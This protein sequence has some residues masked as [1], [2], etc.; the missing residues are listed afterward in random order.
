M[1]ASPGVVQ[2]KCFVLCGGENL[3]STVIE[4]QARYLSRA[5]VL[6][7]LSIGRVLQ[8]RR[9]LYGVLEYSGW[10]EF[11]L[12]QVTTNFMVRQVWMSS[13]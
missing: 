7:A 4:R 11:R 8:G 10:F 2:P 6:L 1:L 9:R 12:L 3:I 5:V 13:R